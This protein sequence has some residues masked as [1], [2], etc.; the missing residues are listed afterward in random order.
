MSSRILAGYQTSEGQTAKIAECIADTLRD[1]GHDV[2]VHDVEPAP[3]GYGA[4]VVGD[5]IHAVK[6]CRPMIRYI[7][8]KV[9]ALNAKPSALF[10]VCLASANPDDEHTVSA[11]AATST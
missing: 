5:S 11:H 4:M 2:D 9:G 1:R 3:S 8:E 7:S 6:H 10:Q